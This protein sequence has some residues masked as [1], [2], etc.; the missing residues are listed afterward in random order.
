[1]GKLNTRIHE[2]EDQPEQ[3]WFRLKSTGVLYRRGLDG[4]CI[5][6]GGRITSSNYSGEVYKTFESDSYEPL[7]E[8]TVIEITL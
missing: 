6:R 8:G 3:L 2:Q 4:L 1:M 7:P 5:S